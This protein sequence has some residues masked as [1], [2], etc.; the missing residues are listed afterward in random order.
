MS[1]EVHFLET[2]GELT[3]G[4]RAWGR[5]LAAVT[6]ASF[7]LATILTTLDALDVTTPAPIFA[8]GAELPD[9]IVTILQNQSLRFPWVLASS[10]LAALSFAA[11]AAL[12]PVL[13]R[14]LGSV[15][16]RASLV[17]GA[18][19]MAGTIGVVA[20]IGFIGGQAVASDT[21]YCDCKFADPQLIARSGMLDLI[22]S[23]EF[24]LISGMLVVFGAGLLAIASLARERDD[25]PGGWTTLTWVL[26]I[27]LPIIAVV[28]V[29][30]PPLARSLQLQIDIDLI[31]GLPSLLVLLVLVPWWALWLR[32]WLGAAEVIDSP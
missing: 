32:G 8:D 14:A 7:A 28:G 15:D 2:A 9:R 23:V 13:R 17:T 22:S 4:W 26:G 12:G 30:V 6:A 18:L 25:L 16:W 27:L 3:P 21:T 24:W 20:E 29:A 11:I 1:E 10:L 31:T 19:L 5:T